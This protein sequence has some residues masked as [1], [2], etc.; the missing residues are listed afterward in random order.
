[1]HWYSGINSTILDENNT[2]WRFLES[3]IQVCY[4]S[5]F[6]YETLTEQKTLNLPFVILLNDIPR[7]RDENTTLSVKKRRK[8]KKR[9]RFVGFRMDSEEIRYI[10]NIIFN[11]KSNMNV[12]SD[13]LHNSDQTRKF[14]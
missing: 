9:R 5:L 4:I 13:Y 10:N 12:L 6:L 14:I 2:S 1:M 11:L 7:S 8:E 3:M